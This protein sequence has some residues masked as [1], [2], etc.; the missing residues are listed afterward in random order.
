[1]M[2]VKSGA[3]VLSALLPLSALSACSAPS[4]NATPQ[5]IAT[6]ASPRHFSNPEIRSD[7]ESSSTGDFGCNVDALPTAETLVQRMTLRLPPAHPVLAPVDSTVAMVCHY[8]GGN[9]EVPMGALLGATIVKDP[10]HL[11]ELFNQSTRR[12][13]Y[14]GWH[15]CVADDGTVDQVVFASPSQGMTYVNVP[16]V[17]CLQGMWSSLAGGDFD[18][19]AALRDAMETLDGGYPAL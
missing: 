3:L 11:A 18:P 12:K 7:V 5:P 4:S 17:G 13:P 2:R 1:M 19:N 6:F 8:A 16:R 15:S 10:Q 14:V 9:D